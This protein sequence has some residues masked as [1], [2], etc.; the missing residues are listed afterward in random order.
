MEWYTVL[1]GCSHG[2][3]NFRP[4]IPPTNQWTLRWKRPLSKPLRCNTNCLV[5]CLLVPL[6]WIFH[7]LFVMHGDWCFSHDDALIRIASLVFITDHF[8]MAFRHLTRNLLRLVKPTNVNSRFFSSVQHQSLRCQTFNLVP[9]YT[10]LRSFSSV[11]TNDNAYRDLETFLQKEIQLEKTA[12]K[13]P[14][15]LPNI[16]N[17]QVSWCLPADHSHRQCCCA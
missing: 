2:Y 16:A 1:Y 12:Q 5:S 9:R 17:F 4:R 14:T 6:V 7:Y 8:Q 13:H 11:Q 3:G 10:S 15:Q